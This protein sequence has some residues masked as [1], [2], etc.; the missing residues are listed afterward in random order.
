MKR[1]KSLDELT[2]EYPNRLHFIAGNL[3]LDDPINPF[4]CLKMKY[5]SYLGR[6]E[7]ELNKTYT[8]LDNVPEWAIT[9]V[10]E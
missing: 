3:F 10:K 1:L 7:N 4:D 6:N 5:L 2:S 8:S 9:K